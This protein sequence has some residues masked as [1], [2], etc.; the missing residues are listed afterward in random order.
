MIWSYHA[1]SVPEHSILFYSILFYSILY[2]IGMRTEKAATVKTIGRTAT[3]K[4]FLLMSII[5]VCISL[6]ALK[7]KDEPT[8]PQQPQIQLTIEDVS[9]TEVWLKLSVTNVSNPIVMLK[10]DDTAIDT[11]YLTTADTTIVDENLLPSHTYT[12]T[13]SLLN[14]SFVSHSTAQTMDTTSHNFTW[15]TFTLGDG[16]ASS[17]LYDVVIINDT[18]AY[19]VG[20]IYSSGSVYNFARWN[21]IEWELR[22]IQSLVCGSGGVYT[23]RELRTIFAFNENDIWYSDGGEIIHWNGS[24][25]T[26]DCS[27]NSMLT[28]AINRIWG[29][30]KNDLYAVGGSGTIVHYNGLS[31]TKIESGTNTTIQ[32][33][34]GKIDSQT[35]RRS[36]ICG[37]S[38]A[39]SIGGAALLSINEDNT[40]SG[41]P[42]VS[43]RRAYSVWFD[44]ISMIYTCGDGVFRR[45]LDLQWKEIAGTSVLPAFTNR[46]RGQAE[47]DL[48]V[49]SDFGDIMHFNGIDFYLFAD[50]K[51]VIGSCELF[52]CDYKN[53]ILIAVGSSSSR[54]VIAIGKR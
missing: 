54:A 26:N 10:R 33:V 3:M 39:Y 14:G 11:L 9:C 28:G 2:L 53:N 50:V 40:V 29:S 22:M 7:C 45:S 4:Q 19:A 27:M 35:G 8:K 46:L 21:G 43:G 18:L 30:S 44:R 12:Y 15:Q 41:V 24:S 31:W 49:V 34:W 51:N 36:I 42:W 25:Y 23:V 16:A 32:D 47:N 17:T 48:F 37:A 38:A 6:T 5:L 13:A 52:S 1:A 20:Q